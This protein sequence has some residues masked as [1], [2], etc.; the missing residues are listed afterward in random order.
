MFL[1]ISE[2]EPF[3]QSLYHKVV[4]FILSGDG[5]RGRGKPASPLRGDE[6]F[7]LLL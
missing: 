1:Q 3:L 2:S 4:F 5:W 7:I 6:K